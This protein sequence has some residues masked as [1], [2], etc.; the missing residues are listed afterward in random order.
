[1]VSLTAQRWHTLLTEVT[2]PLNSN[3]PDT[4]HN[5]LAF[6][7]LKADSIYIDSFSSS[8]LAAGPVKKLRLKEIVFLSKR[9]LSAGSV[10]KETALGIAEGIEILAKA[11]LE[12]MNSTGNKILRILARGLEYF[13]FGTFFGAH[14]GF[15]LKEYLDAP[16]K[17]TAAALK[18]AKSLKAP[19]VPTPSGKIELATK[20]LQAYCE[21]YCPGISVEQASGMIRNGQALVKEILIGNPVQRSKDLQE[22]QRKLAEINWFLTY[23]AL[24]KNQGSRSWSLA[25]EE[26]S[27]LYNFIMKCPGVYE[28]S[29]SHYVGRSRRTTGISSLL[30]ESSSQHGV[31]VKNN[32]MPAEKGTVLFEQIESLDGK[33]FLFFKPEYYGTQGWDL[34]LHALEFLKTQLQKI[35]IQGSHDCMGLQREKVPDDTKKAFEALLQ[36][37]E[38]N[39]ADYDKPDLKK[40]R[41]KAKLF[42][43]AYMKSFIATLHNADAELNALSKAVSNT[44]ESLDNL[45]KRTGREIYITATELDRF[46]SQP[47]SL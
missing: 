2:S 26:G 23:C 31:D 40:A 44:W 42:G 16:E 10:P 19:F 47:I 25:I 34:V 24:Q 27:K 22:S 11:K 3:L 8:E 32:L 13:L 15:T 36:H 28:R 46:T 37:I 12:R 45:D 41:N 4:N 7:R 14:F 5:Y 1:M 18:Y 29:S 17:E 30:M 35:L 43:I 38:N 21:L 33:K 20:D 6:S 39:K 9:V